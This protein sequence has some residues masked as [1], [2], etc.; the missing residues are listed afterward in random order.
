MIHPALVRPIRRHVGE[1]ALPA[2]ISK[3]LDAASEALWD[4]E[5]DRAFTT[6]TLDQL[7]LELEERLENVRISEVRYRTLFDSGP[8]PTFVL[9]RSD[10]ILL[11]WNGAA[12]RTFGW[13][14][15]EV[16]G[17]PFN[18]LHLCQ[19]D[20]A[21]AA[22]LATDDHVDPAE[23]VRSVL[24]ARDR[25]LVEADIQSR[26]MLLN[27]TDAVLVMI[28]DVTALNRAEQSA[29]DNAARFSAF[30][31]HAGIAIQVLTA[32]GVITEANA[33]CREM[34]GYAPALLIDRPLASLLDDSES[35]TLQ[36]ACADV[37]SAMRD[38][39]ALE[40]PFR[41]R[42][43]SVVWG[44]LTL[45]RVQRGSEARLIAM[46]QNVGERKRLE[47]ALERQAFRDDLTGLANRVLFRD[48][49][50][51]ALERRA[52]VDA[53]VA[54]LL[55][56]LDGFKRVNDSLGHAAGDAL[57]KVI[58]QRIASL[59]RA[60]ETV[61][62][63]GG[64]EFAIVIEVMTH[65]EDPEHLAER[66]LRNIA[67]PIDLSGREVVVNV[68]IGIAVAEPDE[69]H[70]TV[71]R[72]ADAAMYSAKGL[73]KHRVRRFDS[74]M[75]ARALIRLE[76]EQDLRRALAHEEL[77]L[78]FQPLVRFRTGVLRG[79]EALLRWNHPRR[80]TISP[81]DFLQVAEETGLM[82]DIGRWVLHEACRQASLWQGAPGEESP[83]ISVNLAA[84]QLDDADLLIDVKRALDISG[85][86]PNRLT[87]EITESDV[88]RNPDA[89]RVRLQALRDIGV[90]IAI[91]DFG[92]GYSSLSHLQ[93]FPVDELKIDR[94]FVSRL[95]NGDR[96]SS[97]VRT[98]VLLAQ[99]L[100]VEVVAEGIELNSQ[101][102]ALEMLGCDTGQGFLLGRPLDRE[103]LINYLANLQNPR[104]VDAGVMIEL[105][106]G[107]KSDKDSL[108]A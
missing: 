41:H 96:E 8:H 19:Q 7:S 67:L 9:R 54:V 5:M 15:D 76:I 95:D 78:Y 75:H 72:N 86:H 92:T 22:K 71:L 85:L 30:F 103:Q 25:G 106:P 69:D 55:L 98:M 49:L 80:G 99:S 23:V 35:Q 24:W 88:M 14:H 46:L 62:R 39:V 44:Q 66:L 64:D 90:R 17:K 27:G 94:T 6:R 70:E 87:L 33:A 101:F 102:E 56:D 43:G 91:D 82:V 34:F 36:A 42:D 107:N 29:R 51:H 2:E 52:R 81:A 48:R 53:Q 74:S 50:R 79:F 26:D 11:D 47:L 73:G 104:H 89:A 57:L 63:L 40:L 84:R 16:V 100:G 58:A 108:A 93:Y 65:D 3:V 21:F 31:D 38:S 68:S 77:E 20:C 37:M 12:E 1:A 10:W 28:R 105:A 59:V 32:D 4:L 60:G 97:F 83:S 13:H 61:A 45:A 18:E